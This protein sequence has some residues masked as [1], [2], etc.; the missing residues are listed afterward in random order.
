MGSEEHNTAPLS[1]LGEANEEFDMESCS[2]T[3]SR[4]GIVARGES[5]VRDN[6]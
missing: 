2:R 1:T 6:L 5:G 3:F 4:Y